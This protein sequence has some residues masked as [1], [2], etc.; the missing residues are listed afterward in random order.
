VFLLVCRVGSFLSRSVTNLVLFFLSLICFVG[1]VF[2]L[3]IILYRFSCVDLF[4]KLFRGGCLSN[5]A[6]M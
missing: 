1:E 4:I 6:Y 3:F 2:S 5:L